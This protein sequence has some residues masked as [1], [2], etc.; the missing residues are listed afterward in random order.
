[1]KGWIGPQNR[2][3]PRG[4]RGG[5]RG[6]TPQRSEANTPRG[7]GRRGTNTPRPAN[8]GTPNPARG[9]APRGRGFG[10][11][12]PRGGAKTPNNYYD[13]SP[14]AGNYKNSNNTL[15]NLLYTS[16]PLLRPVIFVPSVLTRILF[17]EE[18]GEELLKAAR[19]HPD[20]DGGQ[21]LSFSLVLDL[22]CMRYRTK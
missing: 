7:G 6:G 13:P 18:A 15:S 11:G 14:N 17:E 9:T 19:V 1:L 5:G 20:E 21:F 16:R 10:I 12:S 3:K 8:R 22:H 2:G 4:G